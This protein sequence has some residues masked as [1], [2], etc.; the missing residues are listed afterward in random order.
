VA[1]R[2][3]T[4]QSKTK[5]KAAKDAMAA[6]AR[7]EWADHVGSSRLTLISPTNKNVKTSKVSFIFFSS[8]HTHTYRYRVSSLVAGDCS[9]WLLEACH[10]L[11]CSTE[12]CRPP[13]QVVVFCSGVRQHCWLPRPTSLQHFFA[14]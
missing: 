4:D 1:L 11:Q 6:A 12:G 2:R 13:R 5:A 3:S 8:L 10:G 9:G 7:A 14:A